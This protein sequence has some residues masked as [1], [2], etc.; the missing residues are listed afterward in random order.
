[1]LTAEKFWA[2]VRVEGEHW[3]W[4][5][6]TDCWGYGH[7]NRVRVHRI[8]WEFLN[9][10]VPEGCRVRIVCGNRLCVR[11][12]EVRL[13][14]VLHGKECIEWR[15]ATNKEGYGHKQKNG[16]RVYVHR[17]VW[18]MV[19]GPLPKGLWVLHKCDNPP[20]YNYDHLFAG[21]PGE[22]SADM[23]RKGR[24]RRST[25]L[26]VEDILA[27]RRRANAGEEHIKI[28]V[29]YGVSPSNISAIKR[30]RSWA[31]IF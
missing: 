4:Q 8:A 15:G 10:P 28:A 25:K 31:W 5:G 20:C 2:L 6:R 24:A 29:D 12:L 26:Q 27:I 14:Q 16:K 22:N 17:E 23:L 19:N 9:G 30:G 7:Y 3:I 1:M 21:T 13:V 18:E 11:H